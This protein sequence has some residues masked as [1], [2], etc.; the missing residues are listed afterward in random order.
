MDEN[1]KSKREIDNGESRHL[2]RFLITIIAILAVLIA[3]MIKAKLFGE[4]T[5]HIG[6]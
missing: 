4:F 5:W 6:W 1:M 3:V 2:K